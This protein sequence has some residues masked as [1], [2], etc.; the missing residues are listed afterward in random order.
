MGK[1]FQTYNKLTWK[2]FDEFGDRKATGFLS[3]IIDVHNGVIYLVPHELEHIEF[4]SKLL[5][6]DKKELKKNPEMAINLI[7][8]MIS[9]NHDDEASGII[10]GVS[11]MELGYWITHIK[12]EMEIAHL[13]S[14]KFVDAG[15]I[16]KKQSLDKDVIIFKYSL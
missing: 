4:V 11:G 9:V 5:N 15:E 6:V 16:P 12:E 2:L 8:S 13:L 10:T 3:L 7:P 1:L 14:H